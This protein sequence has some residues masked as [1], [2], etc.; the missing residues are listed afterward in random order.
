MLHYSVSVSR[1]E[2]RIF[3]FFLIFLDLNPKKAAFFPWSVYEHGKD[4]SRLN[5]PDQNRRI[6]HMDP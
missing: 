5:N 6:H 4:E 3:G 1:E 2:K